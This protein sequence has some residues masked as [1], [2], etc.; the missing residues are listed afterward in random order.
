[1][2]RHRR[3]DLKTI[4]TALGAIEYRDIGSGHP[5]VFVHGVLLNGSLWDDVVFYLPPDLRLIRPDLPLG[6]HRL[7]LPTNID[8]TVPALAKV[9]LDLIEGL[10]LHNVVLVASDGGQAICQCA[11]AGG[12]LRSCSISG[13]LLT[14]C[15]AFGRHYP[16]R[17]ASDA[18]LDETALDGIAW[19]LS[20]S[21]GRRAFFQRLVWDPLPDEQI[22]ELLGGFIENVDVRRDALR[23]FNSLTKSIGYGAMGFNG[24]VKVLWGAEDGRLPVE[25]GQQLAAQYSRGELRCLSNARLLVPLDQPEKTAEAILDIVQYLHRH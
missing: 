23:A 18:P 16:G 5:V 13:L 22:R 12:D 21:E 20:T 3:D 24:P 11:I 8:L 19:T 10:G 7:P 6:G 1:M 4:V 25:T 17:V 14:N 9:L 2:L 15:D